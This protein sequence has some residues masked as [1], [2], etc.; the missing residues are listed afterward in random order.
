MVSGK[1]HIIIIR[2]LF[3][4]PHILHI[5]VLNVFNINIDEKPET[6]P[7]EIRV[8]NPFDRYDFISN[9][10]P[11]SFP[12]VALLSGQ[13]PN[14]GRRRPASTTT[15]APRRAPPVVEYEDDVDAAAAGAELQLKSECPEPNGF[16]ADPDQ[17]DK[18]Y[19]CS[20]NKITEKL[21]PDGKVFNDYS[22]TQEKC[23]LPLNIDCSQRPALR[24]YNIF[25]FYINKTKSLSIWLSVW[26]V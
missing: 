25:I 3:P 2:Y 8:K 19:E 17:C 7:I 4:Y 21:C 11:T 1:R 20:D 9:I 16:F 6:F 24:E 12:T 5:F 13:S 10:N 15:V 18:Y 14:S 26:Y 23:D 22:P